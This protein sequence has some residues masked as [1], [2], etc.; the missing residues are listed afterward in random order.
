MQ[1]ACLIAL[2]RFFPDL[3]LRF[4]NADQFVN[5]IAPK[6]DLTKIGRAQFA[7]LFP[8]ADS[9]RRG[10]VSW[11]DFV[12]FQTI[13]KRPDADYWI[14]FQYFDVYVPFSELLHPGRLLPGSVPQQLT[15]ARL[16]SLGCLF[17]RGRNL[18]HYKF[19]GQQSIHSRAIVLKHSA[20]RCRFFNRLQAPNRR[21]THYSQR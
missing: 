5:A 17:D 7:T 8:V 15:L 4:L 14:A 20:I 13:L 16:R 3:C 11:D 19:R 12:V 10:L 18:L 9:S 6:G 1:S 21:L 2:P